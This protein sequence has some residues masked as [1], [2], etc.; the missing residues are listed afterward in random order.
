M[1]LGANALRWD[2]GPGHYEVWYLTLTDPASGVGVWI[3]YTM[4]AP[5]GG[6][7][8]ATCSLWFLAM[9]PSGPPRRPQGARAR[10]RAPRARPSRSACASA[11][12]TLDDRGDA[13]G[14]EDVAWDLPGRPGRRLPSTSTRSLERARIAKTVLV[15]A[16]TPTSPSR[17]P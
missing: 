14:F 13:G 11:G 2:G 15:A 10:R 16:R 3:R 1:A 4:L 17:A 12:A 9:D 8:E 7:R 6:G 5:L